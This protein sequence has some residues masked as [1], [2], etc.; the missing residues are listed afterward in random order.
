MDEEKTANAAEASP[1]VLTA[2]I[3][4]T[5]AATGKVETFDLVG[6]PDGEGQ[7]SA[8]LTPQTPQEQ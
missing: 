1:A 8:T 7:I 5:R 4:I 2:T 6:I 3:T